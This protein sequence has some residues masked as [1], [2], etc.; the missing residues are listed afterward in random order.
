VN[1]L[2]KPYQREAARWLSEHSRGY[3]AD[4]PGLGKTREAI[5]GAV[6]AGASRVLVISPAV[7]QTHWRREFDLVMP[8][9]EGVIK[10]ASYQKFALNAETRSEMAL[11][12][13]QA[14]VLDEAH[15]LKHRD[16][17][18]TIEVLLRNHL[19]D[20]PYVWP[21]SGTPMPRNPY[22]LYPIVRALWPGEMMRDLRIVSHDQWRERYTY[23]KWNRYGAK[24][25]AARNVDELRRFLRDKMLRRTEAEVLPELP[26]IRWTTYPLTLDDAALS[27]ARVWEADLTPR[28]R[29]ELLSPDIQPRGK[30]A[31]VRHAL[32]RLK[33]NPTLELIGR[34]LDDSPGEKRIVF[35]YHCDV[36]RDLRAGF[37]PWGVAY[38]DGSTPLAEREAAER[39]FREDPK[40]RVFVG[41]NEAAG[42]SLTLTAASRVDLVEPDWRTDF[43]VQDGKRAHR[44]GQTR[45]VLVRML[46]IADSLDEALVAQHHRET[47]MRAEVLE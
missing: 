41:Q 12:D 43:N 7:A 15:M 38:I 8:Y 46:S 35:A 44:I 14:V 22:E 31:E 2:L 13:P 26:P 25:Y 33:V 36:L 37:A 19:L 45:S 6:R 10:V 24:V 28:E 34:E 4:P 29:E 11:F 9:H 21:L 17:K 30:V 40:V 3:L 20:A 18:R 42:L 23:Y 16:S 47:K 27:V 5:A 39:A 32:G 1:D